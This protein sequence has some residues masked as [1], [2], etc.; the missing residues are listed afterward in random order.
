MPSNGLLAW[1]KAKWRNYGNDDFL[2]SLWYTFGMCNEGKIARADKE[3][4]STDTYWSEKKISLASRQIFMRQT[5]DAQHISCQV[6]L[7]SFAWPQESTFS[8]MLLRV[9][10]I[11]EKV[12]VVVLLRDI[13][14]YF[15]EIR[16]EKYCTK[17]CPITFSTLVPL[18]IEIHK[19]QIPF[20]KGMILHVLI[21]CSLFR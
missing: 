20:W 6:M 12:D 18:W 7:S 1:G 2:I 14:T 13:L 15:Q 16:F 9:P 10:F 21:I 11:F 3:G 5:N 4:R 19:F 8:L 17:P